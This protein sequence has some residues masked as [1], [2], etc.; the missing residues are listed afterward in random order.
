MDKRVSKTRDAIIDAYLALIVE[1]RGQKITIAEIAR[2]ANIARKTFYLHYDSPEAV[3]RDASQRKL[4]ELLLILEQKGFFQNPF[5]TG[6]LFQ[7]LNE[8]IEP[9]I[10]FYRYISKDVQDGFFWPELKRLVIATITEIYQPQLDFSPQELRLYAEYFVAGV[11]AVYVCWLRGELSLPF[12]E[13]ARLTGEATF[14]GIR[15]PRAQEQQ[16][17]RKDYAKREP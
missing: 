6:L 16:A 13:L 9:D 12:E 10:E 11:M 4:N 8:I 2:R 3:I 5:D 14:A 17:R 1:N 7:S 15:K